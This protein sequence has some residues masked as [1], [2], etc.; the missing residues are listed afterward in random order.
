M[1][2]LRGAMPIE[3]QSTRPRM[4]ASSA[5]SFTCTHP[6]HSPRSVLEK[7]RG[8]YGFVSLWLCAHKILNIYSVCLSSTI[9]RMLVVTI[10]AMPCKCPEKT[11]TT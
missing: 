11:V 6:A 5:L 8:F 7:C 4:T 2:G 1:S 9:R 3:A 10:R